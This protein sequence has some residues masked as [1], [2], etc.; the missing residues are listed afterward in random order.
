MNGRIIGLKIDDEFVPC[1]TAC[2]ISFDGERISIASK[3]NGN[4]RKSIPGYR[5]WKATVNGKFEIDA[6]PAGAIALMQAIT[7]GTDV[8]V[9]MTLRITSTQTLI[10]G[11]L[12]SFP[13]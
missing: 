1:E 2:D 9:I 10:I 7:N 4:W 5:S 12:L 13:Y 3:E 6:S 11:V 8:Y